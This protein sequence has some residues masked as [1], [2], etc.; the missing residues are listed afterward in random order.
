[1]KYKHQIQLKIYS[2]RAKR[3]ENKCYEAIQEL[4]P[5]II[6]YNSAAFSRCV[7]HLNG[8]FVAKLMKGFLITEHTNFASLHWM[9]AI[10]INVLFYFICCIALCLTMPLYPLLSLTIC[11][12]KRR[13]GTLEQQHTHKTIAI[14]AFFRFGT[15][16][17]PKSKRKIHLMWILFEKMRTSCSVNIKSKNPR[18]NF[19]AFV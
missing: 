2:I 18:D 19:G 12:S 16:E 14:F 3:W 7:C 13:A 11:M 6:L 4:T 9:N 10:E 1:M 5:N 17:E 15:T 8:N